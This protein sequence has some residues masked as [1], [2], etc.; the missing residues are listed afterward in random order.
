M[1]IA[2][3]IIAHK[4]PQQLLR[5]VKRLNH[6]D[7]YF[8]IHIDVNADPSVFSSIE[9]SFKDFPNVTLLKRF[10]SA[11]ASFGIVQGTVEG[12]NKAVESKI[13]FDY[14]INLS[15]QDYPIK[16]NVQ[17]REKLSER[18]DASYIWYFELPFVGTH[19]TKGIVCQKLNRIEQWHV[20]LEGRYLNFPL[21]RQKYRKIFSVKRSFLWLGINL[22]LPKKR[23]FIKNYTPYGGGQWWCLSRKHAEYVYKYVKENKKQYAYFKYTNIPDEIF[24]QTVLLNSPHKNEIVNDDLRLLYFAGDS[25]HPII[26]KTDDYPIIADSAQLFARKFDTTKD[27]L[28]LDL[29]DKHLLMSADK[30]DLSFTNMNGGV[31]SSQSHQTVSVAENE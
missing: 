20:R 24:F 9:S 16:T 6:A 3:I 27:E 15:G 8:F 4:N 2:Y 21:S 7:S 30:T 14:L 17:I 31:R 22:M 18:A 25:S 11:Y 28:V 10:N 13:P 29:I 12:L 19:P 1:K 23:P 5:L 26:Y